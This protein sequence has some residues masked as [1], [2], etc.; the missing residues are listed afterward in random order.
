MRAFEIKIQGRTRMIEN[1]C[2][3]LVFI[4]EPKQSEP[5]QSEKA[6]PNSSNPS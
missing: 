1:S 5:L 6:V 3:V 4:F 2:L